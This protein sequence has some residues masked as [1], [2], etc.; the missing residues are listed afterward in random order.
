MG[1][2]VVV[3]MY[4]GVGSC[5]AMEDI[6]IYMQLSFGLRYRGMYVIRMY[7]THIS[8]TIPSQPSPYYSITPTT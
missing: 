7:P 5:L 2:T 4:A 3:V 6:D 8:A 1:S